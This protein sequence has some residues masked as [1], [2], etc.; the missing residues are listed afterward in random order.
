MK[1]LTQLQEIKILLASGSPRRQNLIKGLDI[2]YEIVQPPDIE[3]K[4]PQGL[5]L[6]DVP[7]F[8]A[9]KK[10]RNYFEEIK[11]G[12]ILI[13][14][15]TV[16]LCGDEI[17]N[18]PKVYAEAFQMIHNLSGNRHTVVTGVCLKS[19][20]KEHV[21]SATTEVFFSELSE[22]EIMYYLDKYQPFDKAGAYG[23]Q[24]WIGY[25]GIDRIE[26]S[27]FNVMGLPLHR[28]YAEIKI[29]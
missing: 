29:F 16:V 26:G 18:K 12:T 5:D 9:R 1:S 19:A 23:I 21:F 25:I 28:L 22:D 20:V 13:T 6:Y 3:E 27:F 2:P 14:A 11:P 15:D 8:L 10:A 7:S 17:L 24:E 4:Y